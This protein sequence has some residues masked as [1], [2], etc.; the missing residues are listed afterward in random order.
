MSLASE[1]CGQQ[2]FV[3]CFQE[4][5]LGNWVKELCICVERTLKREEEREKVESR[6]IRRII[7]LRC[8]EREMERD[9]EF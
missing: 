7:P 5:N 3:G 6:L 2:G 4:E 8:R 1:S 9:H